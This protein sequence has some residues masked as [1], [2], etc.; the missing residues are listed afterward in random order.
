MENYK[1]NG[2]F[3]KLVHGFEDGE[4]RAGIM[5]G[6]YIKLG[7]TKDPE[8]KDVKWLGEEENRANESINRTKRHLTRRVGMQAPRPANVKGLAA[9]RNEADAVVFQ[10]I[11]LPFKIKKELYEF[12]EAREKITIFNNWISCN[13]EQ[14]IR[15]QSD[16]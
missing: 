14:A 2:T 6:E 7:V 16:Q 12:L 8:N 4:K 9:I 15:L 1:H 13:E 5:S 3:G 10:I 11:K